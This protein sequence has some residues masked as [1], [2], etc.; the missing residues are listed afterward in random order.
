MLAAFIP[1]W[2]QPPAIIPVFDHRDAEPALSAARLP[3]PLPF[4]ALR[5]APDRC[6]RYAAGAET[7]QRPAAGMAAARAVPGNPVP[8]A[9]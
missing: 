9:G 7:R 4:R 1:L 2:K 5:H 3:V 6:S 8:G